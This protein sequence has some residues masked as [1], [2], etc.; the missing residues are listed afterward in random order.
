MWIYNQTYNLPGDSLYH[1]ADELYH[2][3]ILGMKWG[4]R[5]EYKPVNSKI[6]K[7]DNKKDNN[8][9]TSNKGLTKKQ[10]VLIGIGAAATITALGVIAYK[11]IK[12]IRKE[13]NVPLKID[14]KTGLPLFTHSQTDKEILKGVNPGNATLFGEKRN[15]KIFTGGNTNCQVCTAAYDMRKRGFDVKAKPFKKGFN[16]DRL[17][18]DIYTNYNPKKTKTLYFK[19]G[20]S[21]FNDETANDMIKQINKACFW[22][23]NGARGNITNRWIGLRSSGHSMIWEKQHG[24]IVFKD[25]QTNEVYKNFKAVLLAS[26]GHVSITRTDK[27]EINPYMVKKYMFVD[28]NAKILVDNSLDI[29]KNLT[30]KVLGA[31]L[32]S[33]GLYEINKHN[34]D[35]RNKKD[36][37]NNDR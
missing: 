21:I 35:K 26:K 24:K 30:E 18:K 22:Y 1:N 31:G 8:K 4:I 20:H 23:P 33:Y 13:Y 11:K 6:N 28:N 27:L 16:T 7:K 14:K 12:D 3:G 29:A 25:A 5:K 36:G 32:A 9:K 17:Y 37:V 10:K 15:F 19:K 34:K 2:Y